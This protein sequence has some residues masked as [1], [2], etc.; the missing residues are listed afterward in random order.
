MIRWN[1]CEIA[2]EP[3]ELHD[4][5]VVIL[6]KD[7]AEHTRTIKPRIMQ[8]WQYCARV[9]VN[10]AEDRADAWLEDNEYLVTDQDL[11]IPR[12]NIRH[13]QYKPANVRTETPTYTKIGIKD[14]TIIE[15]IFV[16][17]CSGM[18]SIFGLIVAVA[19]HNKPG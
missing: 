5:K 4:I 8:D 10:T 15:W 18:V 14:W 13:V 17:V 9:Y 2:L 7:G 16:A 1:S 3:V 12:C 11:R 19:I 6:D